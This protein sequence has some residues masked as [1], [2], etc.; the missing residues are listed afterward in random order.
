MKTLILQ[1]NVKGVLKDKPGFL[2]YAPMIYDISNKRVKEYAC[3]INVDYMCIDNCD[4]LKDYHA[5]WQRFALFHDEFKKYDIIIYMDSDYI[6][7][8]LTPN[9][10]EV[11]KDR[12]EDFFAVIDK[13]GKLGYDSYFNSGFFVIKRNLINI[14]KHVYFEYC[15]KYKK[16]KY[17]DQDCLNALCRNYFL[18]YGKLSTDW[19]GVLAIKR[20][21]FAT[22][23]CALRKRDFKI[24][25]Y[26]KIEQYKINIISNM[27]NLEI[28]SRIWNKETIKK[29][30][31]Y[32][33]KEDKPQLALF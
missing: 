14:L 23:Y 12:D 26:F 17:P 1:V 2:D 22:H 20:P 28:Y 4:Y 7:H 29:K 13:T 31:D 5:M 18:K 27:T 10:L 3:R 15:E 30:T 16:S 19:N 32:E 24:N 25:D 6:T 8:E 33:V 9:L 11:I 21:L